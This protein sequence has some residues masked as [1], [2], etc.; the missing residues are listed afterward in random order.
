MQYR[1]LKIMLVI[2]TLFITI[3]SLKV[4]SQTNSEISLYT[5][6]DSIAGKENLGLNN[7]PFAFNPY[8]TLG[9]NTMYFKSDK[10]TIGTVFY[11]EQPYYNIKLKYD[12]FKDQLILN[13]AGQPEHIGINLIQDKTNSFSIYNK[14]FVLINKNQNSLPEF[15]F[16]YYEL[17]KIGE[18]LSLYIRH[19]KDIL[20]NINEAGAYYTFKENNQYYIDYNAKFYEISNKNSVVKIFPN[21]KKEINDFY[22]K[23]RDLSKTDNDQFINSLMI[24]IYDFSIHKTK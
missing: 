14:N 11:D 1:N 4:H 18:N 8:K 17:I 23:N 13:P 12:I 15:V 24:S 16:G 20:K 22:Q 6:F 3:T 19:H 21:Q 7:G 10:Y 2:S 9:E 5:K